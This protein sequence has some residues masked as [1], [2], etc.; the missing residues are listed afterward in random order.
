MRGSRLSTTLS[1]NK[2]CTLSFPLAANFVSAAAAAT[3]TERSRLPRRSAAVSGQLTSIRR[4]SNLLLGWAWRSPRSLPVER[5]F[6]DSM[7]TGHCKGL[8]ECKKKNHVTS[9]PDCSIVSRFFGPILRQTKRK[10]RSLYK[11]KCWRNIEVQKLWITNNKRGR[12]LPGSDCQRE[13]EVIRL[14]FLNGA[15]GGE[16]KL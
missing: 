15:P 5:Q 9:S 14:K 3:R 16:G 4:E 12:M 10:F 13:R 1:S 2:V 8:L 6:W 11:V 7:E